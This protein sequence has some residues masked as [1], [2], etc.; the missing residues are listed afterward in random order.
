MERTLVLLDSS[1]RSADIEALLPG[2]DQVV[3][4]ALG[5]RRPALLDESYQLFTVPRAA[6]GDFALYERPEV[7]N[8]VQ[9]RTTRRPVG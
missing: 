5:E 2:E 4:F 1:L 3:D 6:V 7:L 8:R 9:L